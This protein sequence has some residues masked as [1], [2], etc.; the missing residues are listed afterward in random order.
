[1]YTLAFTIVCTNVGETNPKNDEPGYQLGKS[2][3]TVNRYTNTAALH[4]LLCVKSKQKSATDYK[5]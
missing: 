5:R 1:M 3:I 2:H 4:R